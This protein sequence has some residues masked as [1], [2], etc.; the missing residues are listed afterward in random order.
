MAAGG[1]GITPIMLTMRAWL[2]RQSFLL[3]LG[4]AMICGALGAEWLARGGHL[5][6]ERLQPLLIGAIFLIA[7]LILPATALWDATRRLRV[8]V[9]VQIFI[10]IALPALAYALALSGLLDTWPAGLRS[11]VLILA[12]LPTTI[13]SC[14]VLTRSAGGDEALALVIAAT[15]SVLGVLIC[16]WTILWLTSVRPDAPLLGVFRDLA[17]QTLVPLAIGQ[18]IRLRCQAWCD[19]Q[20]PALGRWSNRCFLVILA[21][22]VATT[23]ASGS[24]RVDAQ[25]LGLAGAAVLAGFTLALLGARLLAR[26]PWLRLNHG[27]R[28]A[29]QLC[30]SNKSAAIGVPLIGLLA[31][32]RA[33]IGLLCLPVVL[34]HALQLVVGGVLADRWRRAPAVE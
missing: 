17:L 22:V 4:L 33:D 10:L 9:A 15:G 5:H 26:W 12:C 34:Y 6:L 16:P 28:I 18:L 11:G 25:M 27:G 29:V 30:A 20:R 8:H 23:V 21:Y 24:V 31:A 1:L 7:G 32:D 19:R 14:V 3:G 2:R 13:T